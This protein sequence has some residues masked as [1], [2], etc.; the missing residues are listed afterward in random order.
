MAKAQD[1]ASVPARSALSLRSAFKW[2]NPKSR[3][4]RRH[5]HVRFASNE[6]SYRKSSSQECLESALWPVALPHSYGSNAARSAKHQDVER[7]THTP[8]SETQERAKTKSKSEVTA[9]IEVKTSKEE[10]SKEKI[11]ERSDKK[12]KEERKRRLKMRMRSRY[13]RRM[14][15]ESSYEKIEAKPRVAVKLYDGRDSWPLE[16]SKWHLSD[17]GQLL[18]SCL[19]PTQTKRPEAERPREVD[20]LS[21]ISMEVM[22]WTPAYFER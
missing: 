3:S 16:I 22:R 5:R 17:H 4:H 19:L 9:N 21:R 13:K 15:E 11:E 1:A 20:F 14:N 6:K 10:I 2:E 18:L 8:E 12:E 7:D